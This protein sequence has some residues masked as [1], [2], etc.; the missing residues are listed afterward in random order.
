MAKQHQTFPGEGQEMPQPFTRPEISR[1]GDQNEPHAP[2][3]DNQVI[4]DEYPPGENSP[5][6]PVVQPDAA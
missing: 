4:P 1:P 5:E 2:Q 3:E 6:S